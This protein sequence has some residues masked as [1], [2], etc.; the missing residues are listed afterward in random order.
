MRMRG[1]GGPGSGFPVG[2]WAMPQGQGEAAGRGLA[3]AVSGALCVPGE[4][5]GLQGLGNLMQ[6]LPDTWVQRKFMQT[7]LCYSWKGA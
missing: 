2:R 7:C 3:W 6:V 5:A 4:A 1:R